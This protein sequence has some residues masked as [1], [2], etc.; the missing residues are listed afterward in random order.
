[1]VRDLPKT[2]GLKKIEYNFIHEDLSHAL[3]VL[4]RKDELDGIEQVLLELLTNVK[5]LLELSYKTNG[6]S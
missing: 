4:E 1:M 6:L 2:K 3:Y 5:D